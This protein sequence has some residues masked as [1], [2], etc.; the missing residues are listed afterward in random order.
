M[1]N[2]AESQSCGETWCNNVDHRIPGMPF[3]AVEQQDTNR[4]DK[5]KRLIQH[6][7]SHP[8]KE[9]SLQD[10]NQ[11]EEINDV[12]KKS[13]KL[14]ADMNNTEIF[15]LCETSSKKECSDCN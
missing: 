9:S 1:T 12:T 13:Q 6:F 14:I 4:N 15:E 7:Q 5:V 3:A 11:T 10:L 8:N 2:Q